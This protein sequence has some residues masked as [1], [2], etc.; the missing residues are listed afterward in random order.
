MA[1]NTIN[2]ALSDIMQIQFVAQLLSALDYRY[3]YFLF[4]IHVFV[5]HAFFA[6]GHIKMFNT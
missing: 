4:L 5:L 3:I 1:Y 2:R 6:F